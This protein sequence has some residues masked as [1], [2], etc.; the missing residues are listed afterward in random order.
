MIYLEHFGL[1]ESPFG[2][3]PDTS[4]FCACRSIEEALATLSVA[5]DNGEG[6]IKI[7]GEVGT[8][9]TLLCRKFL[10]TLGRDWLAAYLPNPSI[11]PRTLLFALAEELGCHPESHLDEHG[12]LRAINARLLAIADAGTRAIVCIDEAQAMPIKTME[13]V[14][15]LTNLETEKRKLLQVVLFGQPELDQ[16]LARPEI[17]QLRQR[18]T[19][20][21]RMA[22]LTPDETA[23]YLAHRLI[24]AGYSGGGVFSD[25]AARAIHRASGG[26]PRLV[27]ILAHKTLMLAYGRGTRRVRWRE[28]RSAARDTP[29]AA[30]RRALAWLGLV[31]MAGLLA[32][33]G[34]IGSWLP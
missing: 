1:R 9:K 7:T 24:V 13:T 12:L 32:G 5:A 6:F 31:G 30:P 27:N 2:I 34:W 22:P 23:H 10:A 19:F 8:G 3:T 26:V 14:R 21:Y 15:L 28:A 20:E 29:A 16:K 25:G 33:G 11:N 17:R 18:I 4:F